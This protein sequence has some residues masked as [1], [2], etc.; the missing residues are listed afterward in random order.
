MFP[1]EPRI[2][3][4]QA[5]YILAVIWLIGLLIGLPIVAVMQLTYDDGLPLCS[6][7]GWPSEIFRH[8]YSVLSFGL[9]YAIPLPMIAAV[10][11]VIVLKLNKAARETSDG[12]GF[13]T[14]KAKGRVIRMLIIVVVFYFLC[15]LPYH[16]TFLWMEFGEGRQFR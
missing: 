1:W 16:T 6:E 15:Y 13:R 7:K 11:T 14:A 3:V 2:T 8:G 10:Y 12:E 9:T 4:S 5:R